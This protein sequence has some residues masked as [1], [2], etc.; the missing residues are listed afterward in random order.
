MD[1]PWEIIKD[2]ILYSNGMVKFREQECYHS[3]KDVGHHFFRME[4]LDW[5]NVVPITTDNQVVL[6]RQY[7]FGTEKFTLEL[8]G[9]TLDLGEDDPKL[10]AK[11]EML[12][13][14]GYLGEE[15]VSL[16]N[17][18]VN[19]A[20]QNNY[21]H[22][23]LTANVTKVQQQE[24]DNSEDIEIVLASWSEIDEL[25]AQQEIEHS[26]TVLGIMYAQRYLE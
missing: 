4:F 2:K 1:N 22:F 21:C 26:L 13:E 20:I 12:E 11:R 16:G 18:A 9:G 17:V 24:L 7:R 8:P 10:A 6:V 23:Y 19:P 14:T 3:K 25:I 5:V 15:L